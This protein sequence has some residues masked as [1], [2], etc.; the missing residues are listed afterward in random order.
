MVYQ[1]NLLYEAKLASADVWCYF[2]PLSGSR[3]KYFNYFVDTSLQMLSDGT[4]IM[5]ALYLAYL[6]AVTSYV[7]PDAATKRS[8]TEGALRILRQARMKTSLPLDCGCICLLE[9]I[10]GLT[11]RRQYHP[12]GMAV[13]QRVAWSQNIGEIAQHDDFSLLAEE[14]VDHTGRFN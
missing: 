3:I 4:G 11:P 6:H 7:L 2:Q 14:I 5:G 1:T 13:M 8:G 10:A 12:H 9:L